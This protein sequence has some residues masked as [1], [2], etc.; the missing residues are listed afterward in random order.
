MKIDKDCFERLLEFVELFPHYFIGSNADLPIVGG[1]ILSHDHFQGGNYIFPMA[2]AEIKEEIFFKEFPEVEAGIV[3]WPLSVIRLRGTKEDLL[4]L[5]DIILEKWR[6]YSDEANGILS[7]TGEERHNTLTP[8]ARFRDNSFELD[9]VLR[10]NR[11][12]KEHPLGIFHPHSE[13]H[14]IK[15]ENIGLIEVMG[16]AV[17]P[18][19][20]SE[21][22][23]IIKKYLFCENAPELIANNPETAKHTEWYKKFIM[24]QNITSENI[25]KIIN[26]AIGETFSLVLEDCGVFKD[27]AAGNKG[28]HKFLDLCK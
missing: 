11:T 4:N 25:D 1:S 20:L 21:E 16:L 13:Y 7:H 22:M 26:N 10:N 14:N 2:V 8:I 5:A 17:L 27:T 24:S 3:K 23:S 15:K 19:R 18:G 28:F 12:T 6:N 9:L